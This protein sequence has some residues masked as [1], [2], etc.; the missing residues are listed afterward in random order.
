VV[1]P[2]QDAGSF[3]LAVA[4]V[5]D[6]QAYRIDGSC[7]VAI[8]IEVRVTAGNLAG[9]GPQDAH[10]VAEDRDTAR[11]VVEVGS[12]EWIVTLRRD[13]SSDVELAQ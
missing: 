8:E 6:S 7:V 10:L 12:E 3:T 1:P 5:E 11:F 2:G 4:G 9:T 13:G